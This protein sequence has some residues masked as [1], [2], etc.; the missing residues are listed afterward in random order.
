M[1]QLQDNGIH[2]EGLTVLLVDDHDSIRKAV[3]RVL[4]RLKIGTVIDVSDG[5]DALRVLEQKSVDLVIL[6]LYMRNVGGFEVLTQI[7]NQQMGFDTPVVIVTGEAS[8]ED[9][10]KAADLGANDYLLKPF[11]PEDLEKKVVQVLSKT[12]NPPPLLDKLRQGEKKFFVGDFKAA[13]DRFEEALAIDP[14]SI[15]AMHGKGIAL[16]RLGQT[17]AATGLLQHA[18]SLNPSYHKSYAVL[19]DMYH[20]QGEQEPAIAAMRSELQINSKQP[21]RH[22]KLAKMLIKAGD[23]EGAIENLREALKVNPKLK[24]GLMGMGHTYA[25]LDNIEKSLYYFKRVRRYHGDATNALEAAVRYALDAGEPRKAELLL[26]DEKH[27]HPGRLDTYFIL[28]KFYFYTEEKEKG[29]KFLDELLQRQPENVRALQVKGSMH[30]K[31]EEYQ[32]AKESFSKALNHSDAPR[33]FVGLAEAEMGLKKI[34]DGIKTLQEA[35]NIDPNNKDAGRLL[36]EAQLQSKQFLKAYFL[37]RK[38]T[39]LGVDPVYCKGR[40]HECLKH[41]N[42]RRFQ[43]KAAS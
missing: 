8:K 21:L 18:L 10:V 39:K 23:L 34:G 5:N 33:L 38:A 37:F 43:A 17:D 15:R 4:N 40:V 30:L 31:Y 6:D 32:E 22:I 9:I 25:K 14:E 2:P 3:A 24:A 19:A 42:V 13:K 11:V 35:L 28:A 1:N 26:R 41:I 36:A 7:R 27:N 16:Q 12:L 20:Q 29:F